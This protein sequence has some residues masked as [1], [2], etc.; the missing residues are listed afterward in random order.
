MAESGDGE[1]AWDSTR[2]RFWTWGQRRKEVPSEAEEL[3]CKWRKVGSRKSNFSQAYLLQERFLLRTSYKP[4]HQ[5]QNPLSLQ[6]FSG[7]VLERSAIIPHNLCEAFKCISQILF[8]CL[9]YLPSL[10]FFLLFTPLL[11]VRRA[12]CTK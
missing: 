3:L 10:S 7:Y 12:T 4:F 1:H 2:L 6:R 8:F 11:P 9:R 5:L